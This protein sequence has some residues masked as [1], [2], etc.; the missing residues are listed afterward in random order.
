MAQTIAPISFSQTWTFF[1]G[2]WHDGNVPIIGPRTHA[3]WVR[4]PM[5]GTLPSC[6]A[7]SKKVQVWEKLTGAVVRA[8]IAIH[9]AA[10]PRTTA[11]LLSESP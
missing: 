4:G 1:E 2:A 5:I 6:Q 3:A 11:P 7:P 10:V 9:A 8:M